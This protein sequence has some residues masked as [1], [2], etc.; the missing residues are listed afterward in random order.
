M[1]ISVTLHLGPGPGEWKLQLPEESLAYSQMPPPPMF[2]LILVF[3]YHSSPL[4]CPPNS[5]HHEGDLLLCTHI[6]FWEHSSHYRLFGRGAPGVSLFLASVR[7]SLFG[8]PQG[9]IPRSLY[10]MSCHSQLQCNSGGVVDACCSVQW[11]KVRG[12][13][14]SETQLSLQAIWS[15]VHDADSWGAVRHR[16][17]FHH[18][19]VEPHHPHHGA[20]AAGDR[21]GFRLG[22]GDPLQL[23]DG[24]CPPPRSIKSDLPGIDP[25]PPPPKEVPIALLFSPIR[26][27]D[28]YFKMRTNADLEASNA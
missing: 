20:G 6:S 19:G 9:K 26:P 10:I 8:L 2:Q 25:P 18:G 14:G 4:S 13:P 15:Q 1:H 3:L 7:L 21:G 11:F 22:G 28:V 24:S 27:P 17:G 5:N 16:G 12:T 23:R